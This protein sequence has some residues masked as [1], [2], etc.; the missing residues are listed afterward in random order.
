[1]YWYSIAT[2]LK[3]MSDLCSSILM[4][5]YATYVPVCRC[6]RPSVPIGSSTCGAWWW[7]HDDWVLVRPATVSDSQHLFCLPHVLG[8]RFP[9]SRSDSAQ[10]CAH[11][12]PMVEGL[13]ESTWVV[14]RL[15]N[16]LN[17][18]QCQCESRILLPSMVMV[19]HT[20]ICHSTI[21][22][23]TKI[24]KLHTRICSVSWTSFLGWL[25]FSRMSYHVALTKR[26][27][28]RQR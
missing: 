2:K 5:L 26:V 28:K 22:G 13:T 18:A 11:A 19:C 21:R 17:S 14:S 8:D 10:P 7:G 4:C 3:Y 25:E 16:T 12:P 6:V 24:E 23:M 20:F 15:V 27:C 1:M 9:H